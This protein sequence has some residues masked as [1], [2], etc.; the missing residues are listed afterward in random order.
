[1]KREP[2]T[3]ARSLRAVSLAITLVSVVTFATMVY[4][5]Y[6]DVN[7]VVSIFGGRASGTLGSLETKVSGNTAR[8]TLNFTVPND[9]LYPLVLRVSCSPPDG[10][11]VSCQAIDLTVTPGQT[12][13]VHFV[14]LVSDVKGLNATV[15]P[16]NR[17]HVNATASVSLEPFATLSVT[18]DLG[19]A[20]S[21]VKQ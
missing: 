7:G 4:S 16:G 6:Q 13:V 1:M 8:A 17:L 11:P 2:S 20:L 12:Q 10:L 15:A 21:G 9:G 19:S 3:A 18:F 5:A 14:I